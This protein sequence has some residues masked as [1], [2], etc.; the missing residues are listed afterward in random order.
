MNTSRKTTKK[1]WI[2]KGL[3]LIGIVLITNILMFYFREKFTAPLD[4]VIAEESS[5]QVTP[6]QQNEIIKQESIKENKPASKPLGK[7]VY[8]TFDDGPSQL[9]GQFLDILKEHE[10]KATFFMQGGQLQ[11]KNFQDNVKRATT[12][13]HYVGAH[14]MTHDSK[15]LYTDGQFVHEME[16]TLALIHTI[17]GANPKLVRAPYG[18][19]PG[20]DNEQL[21]NQI[22]EANIKVWD[23]TIDSLDWNLQ[24]NPY[25][26]V[27]NIKNGTTRDV[28]VV[29][30]H[31]VR[32]TLQVL[33]EI[34]SFY[35]ERGYKF[36]VYND[37]VHFPLNFRNDQ[38]L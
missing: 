13:G 31:E 6:K 4:K 7:V 38:Q 5:K 17:T 34:I 14:S 18:S 36:G 12:E 28:E 27:E 19:V 24:N 9:T 26:I 10:V 33:P 16:E 21:L 20:L 30:M 1:S 32:Q 15:R 11:N 29:L 3:M 23:W 8:L 37:L 25:Q 35:K 22:V 2:I